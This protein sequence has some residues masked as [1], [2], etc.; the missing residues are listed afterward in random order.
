M[1]KTPRRTSFEGL[2]PV[3][4]AALRTGEAAAPCQIVWTNSGYGNEAWAVDTPELRTRRSDRVPE[5]SRL[6][7]D[8][9]KIDEATALAEAL[10]VPFKHS[11]VRF[12]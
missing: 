8:V 2:E 4:E 10:G 12:R 3:T 11:I 9:T 7:R 5:Q 1:F 6:I